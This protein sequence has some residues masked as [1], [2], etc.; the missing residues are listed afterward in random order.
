M[1][2][3]ILSPLSRTEILL[4]KLAGEFLGLTALVAA[5]IP[6]FFLLI[7]LGGLT[8]LQIGAADF[9]QA[10]DLAGRSGQCST[11]RY[12]SQS[13]SPRGIASSDPDAPGGKPPGRS[14]KSD[15]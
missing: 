4:G 3:L 14:P 15:R 11:L 10:G 5:G 9:E 8:P 1:D 7:P 2:L 13:D 12:Q 6:V